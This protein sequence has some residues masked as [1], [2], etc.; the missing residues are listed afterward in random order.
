VYDV[1]DWA[2]ARRLFRDGWTKTAIAAKLGMSR[3]T[4]A[5]LVG[6]E[7]P[8][9]YERAPVGSMLDPFADAIAAML[10]EDSK[11]PATVIIE[12]LRPLG[13]AGGITILK[14]RVAKLRP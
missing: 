6:S 4:V 2:E 11:V 10:A 8:P 13:Y 12:R 9:R 14:E 5:D 7:T 1:Q 3:N